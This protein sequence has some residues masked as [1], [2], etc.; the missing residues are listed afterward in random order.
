[1]PSDRQFGLA[2]DRARRENDKDLVSLRQRLPG[3]TRY[4]GTRGSISAMPAGPEG[5]R[6]ATAT[7]KE[8]S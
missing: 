1:M 3:F 4:G 7:Q 2:R 5:T 8:R 6:S